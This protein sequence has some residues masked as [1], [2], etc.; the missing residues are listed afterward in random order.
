MVS[1]GVVVMVGGGHM[2]VP[3]GA[4]SGDGDELVGVVIRVVQGLQFQYSLFFNLE[5]GMHRALFYSIL[6]RSF[7]LREIVF[8]DFGTI[9]ENKNCK[10]HGGYGQWPGKIG[11]L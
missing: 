8:T 9:L 10:L 2:G 11:N 4:S 5:T 3:R 6:Y 7:F 1:G